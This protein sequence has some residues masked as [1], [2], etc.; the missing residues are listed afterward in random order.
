MDNKLH[1][2]LGTWRTKFKGNEVQ[3]KNGSLPLMWIEDPFATMIL[4]F[5]KH[6]L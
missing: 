5:T 6:G 3:T 4:P 2:I 1:A